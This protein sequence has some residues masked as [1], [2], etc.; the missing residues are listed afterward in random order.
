MYPIAAGFT[1]KILDEATAYKVVD[2]SLIKE[3]STGLPPEI[4]SFFFG[5]NVSLDIKEEKDLILEVSAKKYIVKVRKKDKARHVLKLSNLTEILKIRDLKVDN[6]AIL[7]SKNTNDDISFEVSIK[8]L[9]M[10][11]DN[12]SSLPVD[13][14]HFKKLQWADEN[15]G[16][17]VPWSKLNLPGFRICSGAEGIY[18]PADTDYTLSVKQVLDSPYADKLPIDNPDGS[19]T[20]EYFQKGSNLEERDSKAQNR[21]LMKC[22]KYRIPVIVC[23]QKTRK[24]DKTTYLIKGVGLVT[25][26]NNGYFIIKSFK[27][28]NGLPKVDYLYNHQVAS[29]EKKVPLYDP[30]SEENGREKTFRY[31]TL[32]RGQPKFRKD[33]ISAYEGRCAITDTDVVSVLEAAHITKYNGGNSNIIPNGI[34][35]RAD[36]HTLWDLGLIAIDETNYTVIVHSSLVN[37]IYQKLSGK[38][39]FLPE[40]KEDWPSIACLKYQR[41]LFKI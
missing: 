37:T 21:G 4:L 10:E 23:I 5:S 17:V 2:L 8:L 27:L 25:G 16:K 33:L 13:D 3:S 9:N 39:I 12:T 28:S 14:I 29:L 30:T 40:S 6:H 26:W 15:S 1:W 7:F 32:R 11:R 36:L 41:E 19:W 24:P 18:K 20:Y 31:L 35:M 22:L 34:I 38:K